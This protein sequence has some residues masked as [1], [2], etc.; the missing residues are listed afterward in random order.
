GLLKTEIDGFAA[1]S[2]I[3]VGSGSGRISF[4]LERSGATAYLLDKS[5]Q[6]LSFSKEHFSRTKTPHKAVCASIFNMPYP[7][8]AFD[9]VWNAGVIEHFIGREQEDALKEMVRICKRGG[10][11]ITLNPYAGSFLHTFGKCIIEKLTQ[12][13]FGREIP[14][15]SLKDC[16]HVLNCKLKKDEYSAGFFVLGVGMFKRLSLLPMG[17]VFKPLLSVLN[18][19]SCN[20]DNSF[21]GNKIKKTDL[22]FSKVFGGYLLVSILQKN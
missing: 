14:I 4:R 15:V 6:A 21:L 11:I 22:M 17:G 8:N 16:C 7:D 18:R 20:L 10:I 3:E 12:Y 13:P 5:R 19:A 9:V 2:F 1:K